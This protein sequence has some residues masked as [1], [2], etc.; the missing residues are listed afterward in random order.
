[1]SVL[2]WLLPHRCAAI[3]LSTGL[4]FACIALQIY[5]FILLIRIILSW[6]PIPRSGP[7]ATVVRVL[8]DVTDPVLRPLR[9]LVPPARMGMM[10]IDFSPIIVFIG[11]SVIQRVIGCL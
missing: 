11:L 6:F 9:N 10:A 7:M 4:R 2:A 1:M 5:T 3:G 8:Y